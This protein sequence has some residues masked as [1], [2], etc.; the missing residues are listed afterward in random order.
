VVAFDNSV[1][2]NILR[3]ALFTERR[4]GGARKYYLAA[5]DE[6]IEEKTSTAS[7]GKQPGKERHSYIDTAPD[8]K[9]SNLRRH[10]PL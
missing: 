9:T 5:Y 6:A 10:P 1:P 3:S 2:S 8:L 4:N 7:E